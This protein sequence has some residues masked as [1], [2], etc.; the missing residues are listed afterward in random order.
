MNTHDLIEHYFASP[1]HG[2]SMGSF[3]AI[4]EFMWDEGEENR[5]PYNGYLGRITPRGAVSIKVGDDIQPIAYEYLSSNKKNW[6][7]GVIFCMPEDKAKMHN[8][9]VLTELGPDA[10]AIKPEHKN[11]ILF[12]LGLKQGFVDVMI[13]TND[14]ALI[15][16]LRESQGTNVLNKDS[17]A[18]PA[19]I[20]AGPNRIFN[21][22]I[23]RLEVYQPIGIEKSPEGPHTHVL[24]KLLASGRACSANIPLPEGMLP[25]LSLHPAHPCRDQLGKPKP[26]DQESYQDFQ[27]LLKQYATTGFYQQKQSI[28]HALQQ[29]LSPQQ[30]DTG[31]S[32]LLRTASR[33]VLRQEYYLKSIPEPI[34]NTWR[35]ALNDV[36]DETKMNGTH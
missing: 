23:G 27:A 6:I 5:L 29:G 9:G 16:I 20:K 17:K 8:R 30:V 32:R 35:E 13:R 15:K 4:G 10:H 18:M 31:D 24:P 34:I 33:A 36:I 12:D 25:V 2:W 14:D 3:G 7:H 11:H 26:F 28:I 1:N 22:A 19:I 21:T